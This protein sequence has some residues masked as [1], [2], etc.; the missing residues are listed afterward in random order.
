MIMELPANLCLIESRPFRRGKHRITHPL[1]ES[2]TLLKRQR[3]CLGNDRNDVDNLA[4]LFHDDDVNRAKRVAGGVDEE[5]ATV[6]TGVLNVAV[7]HS[8][9]FFAEIRAVLVLDIFDDRV[10]AA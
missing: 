7:T 9:E 1:F 6:D 5:Q 4:E 8:G 3:I 10:P 2:I